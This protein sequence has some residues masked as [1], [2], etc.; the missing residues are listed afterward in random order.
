M[1]LN[2]TLPIDVVN[3]SLTALAQLQALAQNAQAV[4]QQAAQDALPKSE[5]AG[6]ELAAPASDPS[7]GN[8]D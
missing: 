6:A 3:V 2:L 1:K 7:S 8:V 4:L 5:P